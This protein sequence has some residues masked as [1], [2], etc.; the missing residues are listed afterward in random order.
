MKIGC[1][2]SAWNQDVEKAMSDISALGL[3]GMETFGLE[4]YYDNPQRFR[5][6]LDKFGLTLS[7]IYHHPELPEAQSQALE[8][9]SAAVRFLKAVKGEFLILQSGGFRIKG[10]HPISVYDQLTDTMNKIGRIGQKYGIKVA[11]HPHI[12]TMGQTREELTIFMQR[13]DPDLVGLCPD[14]AHWIRAGVDPYEICQTYADRVSYV[15]V[16]DLGA[17]DKAVSIGQGGIDQ[18]A[19]MKPILAAGFDGWIIIECRDEDLPVKESMKISGEY[20]K[21]EFMEK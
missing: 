4:E 1:H 10:G 17:D 9:A 21:K 13:L 20:L 7:G 14:I 15:H 2:D 6:L 19:F 5:A 11:L 12:G 3:E 8:K 16:K 18:R